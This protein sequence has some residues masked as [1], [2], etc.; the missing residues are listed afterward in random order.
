MIYF[1]TPNCLKN[2]LTPILIKFT[3]F[4]WN[5]DFNENKG[6]KISTDKFIQNFT[7]SNRYNFFERTQKNIFFTSSRR[8]YLKK[9]F[10]T[11]QKITPEYDAFQISRILSMKG[12]MSLW[13]PRE[14]RS[15]LRVIREYPFNESAE[16]RRLPRVL[17][18]SST[19]CQQNYEQNGRQ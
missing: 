1:E 6:E 19:P 17:H 18:A 9:W 8:F 13:L 2:C 16:I 3:L 10:L 7:T 5:L 4:A 15:I 14:T 11:R 12:L